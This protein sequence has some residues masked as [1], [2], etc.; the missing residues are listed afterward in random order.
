[1]FS[2]GAGGMAVRKGKSL[3]MIGTLWRRKEIRA[4]L[5]GELIKKDKGEWIMMSWGEKRMLV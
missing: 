4:V 3:R 1:M 2:S 5:R